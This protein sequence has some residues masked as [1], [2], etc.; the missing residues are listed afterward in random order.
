M[1]CFV[2]RTLE[3][4]TA[5]DPLK[6]HLWPAG[7]PPSV[8]MD[9]L[10]LSTN[11][12][13]V[14]WNWSGNLWFPLD[15]HPSSHGWFAAHVLL[16]TWYHSIVFGAFHLATQAF[17][18]ETFTVLSEGTIFDATLSPLIRYV[19]SILT[20]AFA[21]VAI[22]AIVHLVY[23]IA[24]LIGV[25]ALRQ[26]PAQWPPVFDKPWKADLLGDFWGYRWHQPFQRT[27]VVVGG[28]PLGNAFGRNMCWDHSSHQ[29]QS[30]TSW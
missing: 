10:D 29:G 17:S 9:A 1:F 18:P 14:S 24:T 7:S 19:R 30:T 13:G 28:W 2:V 22:F 27:F 12:L 5:K 3:W 16:S 8:F 15:T 4:K 23:D 21:S 20:T 6:R 26:D 25:V 11:V